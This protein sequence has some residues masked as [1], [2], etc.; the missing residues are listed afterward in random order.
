MISR[1]SWVLLQLDPTSWQRMGDAFRRDNAQLSQSETVSLLILALG[2]VVLVWFLHHYANRLQSKR[3][4]HRPRRL[5]GQL[6][7]A[8]RLRRRD[9]KLL[10]Q[11]AEHWR[12]SQPALLFIRPENFATDALPPVLVKFRN[13]IA[14]LGR[15]LFAA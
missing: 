8:H 7:R 5:F 4:Y 1:F 10:R 12:L 2:A 14:D 6:C 13:E 11:L 3:T 15:R 9:R